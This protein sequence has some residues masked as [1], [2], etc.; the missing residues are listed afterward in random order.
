[1]IE[2]RVTNNPAKFSVNIIYRSGFMKGGSTRPPP[3]WRMSK[4]PGLDRVNKSELRVDIS[5]LRVTSG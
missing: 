4:K 1:M 2:D 3:G 5:E